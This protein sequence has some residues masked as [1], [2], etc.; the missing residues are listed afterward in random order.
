VK[1]NKVIAAVSGG[2]DSCVMLHMLVHGAVP[3][4]EHITPEDIVVAHVNH[5]IRGDAADDELF[6]GGLAVAYGASFESVRLNL[7]A[8]SSEDTAR[9]AR[10]KF[11]EAMAKKYHTPVILL[12]HH[13]QDVIETAALNI[14]RGT[15]RSGLSS[16][17]SRDYRVRPLL[18]MTKK[19]I[20]EYA[21]TNGI[22]W[23]EDST[24]T[25][26]RYL[27]NRIRTHLEKNRETDQYIKFEKELQKID[28]LNT[29]IDTQIA[30]I[31]QYKIR[32]L[33]VLDRS[34][35]VG[36]EHALSCEL[37]RNILIKLKVSNI[38]KVLVEKLVIS[39]KAAK[40]GTS[41][42]INK[43]LVGL[44]TKRSLRIVNRTTRSTHN[45]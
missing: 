28:T 27:R 3:G 43:D 16:L 30:I 13:K 42:D 35:F 37:M 36:L 31:L 20:R 40:P 39:L 34:L 7:G 44:I 11:L 4:F 1:N 22:E 23:R 38:D 18:D 12:A 6:V 32:K 19:A 24:N 33:T 45:V 10:Y 25:D 15:G 2:I 9:Q 29:D 41:A 14:V 26:H 17:K 21:K 5:G 8:N